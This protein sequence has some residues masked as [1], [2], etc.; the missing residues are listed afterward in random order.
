MKILYA[1]VFTEGSTNISQRDCLRKLGH[2]VDEFVPFGKH[3][4]DYRQ[5]PNF[6]IELQEVRGYDIILI[7]KGNGISEYTMKMLKKN[8]RKIIYWFP[9]P[10]QTFTSE[11]AMKAFYSDVAF[12]DKKNSLEK[13]LLVNKN[14]K[15]VCEGYDESADVVQNVKKQYDIS[16][17]GNV[18]GNRSSVLDRLESVNIISSAYGLQHSIE[19]GKTEINLNICTDSCASDRIYKVLA[20]GGFLLTDDWYGRELTGLVDGED[21]VIYKDVEDLQEKIEFYLSRSYTR[22]KIASRGLSKVKDLTR[23]EWA[24]NITNSFTMS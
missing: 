24:K 21:L 23:M 22:D 12:F 11:M 10:A 9:D 19:V 7:A 20:A 1:G 3:G 16:F 5:V 13:A 14:S 8:N 15:Y 4:V 18:Y 6:N 17:I 2:E